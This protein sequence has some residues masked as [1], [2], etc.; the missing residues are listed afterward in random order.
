MKPFIEFFLKEDNYSSS[1][2]IIAEI[3]N[4]DLNY[5]PGEDIYWVGFDNF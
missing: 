1:D 3:I 4:A 5:K 2:D